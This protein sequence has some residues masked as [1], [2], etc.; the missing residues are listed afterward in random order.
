MY[1]IAYL[2]SYIYICAFV[3]IYIPLFSWWVPSW[4]KSKPN[5]DGTMPPP[6]KMETVSKWLHKVNMLWLPFC[7]A[8]SAIF[9]IIVL[10]EALVY[11][12]ERRTR[13]W[14]LPKNDRKTWVGRGLLFLGI[15]LSTGFGYGAF[16]IL[17]MTDL[18]HVKAFEYAMIVV[19]VQIN[20]GLMIGAMMQKR[21]EKRAAMKAKAR[22]QD[23]EEQV[24]AVLVDEKAALMAGQ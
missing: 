2:L 3:I 12:D 22:G 7:T 13:F 14:Q 18:A 19:P 9:Y 4:P 6:S 8:I 16:E 11:V 10:L 1:H 17:A 5:P 23:V 20:F 21:I 24:S 15:T